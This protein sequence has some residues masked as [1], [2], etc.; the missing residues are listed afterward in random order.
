MVEVEEAGVEGFS[1]GGFDACFELGEEVVPRE[2]SFGL[3]GVSV[4]EAL[5][6][7][8]SDF[9]GSGD[10]FSK[11]LDD[12]VLPGQFVEKAVEEFVGLGDVEN[13]AVV[14]GFAVSGKEVLGREEIESHGHRESIIIWRVSGVKFP[15]G[16]FGNTESCRMVV[17][18]GDG[19]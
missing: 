6:A 12:V 11:H 14:D 7:I 8:P 10:G 5:V 15:S 2:G 17:E 1:G 16:C 19:A 9:A 3:S 4:V 13:R 18:T